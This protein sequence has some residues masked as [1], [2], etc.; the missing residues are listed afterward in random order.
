[1][2]QLT[3]FRVL[4]RLA[5][6][7]GIFLTFP[8][9]PPFSGRV[10]NTFLPPGFMQN[11]RA[12]P[13]AS[14]LQDGRVLVAGGF[15][16][17]GFDQH[18]YVSTEFFDPASGAFYPGPDM[19]APRLGHAAVTLEDNRI[20]LLGGWSA[21]GVTNT[22]EVYDPSNRRFSS[23][24]SM[25]IARGECTATLLQDGKVL[26]T[27]GVDQNERGLS[28]AEVFDPRTNS[29]SS[30]ASMMVPR[31][32]HTAT[33][34]PD[35]S[36]LIT[37]GGS[38][39]CPSKTV[40]RAAEVYDP[41]VG[42]FIPVGGLTSERYKH[43]AVLL[44]DGKVLVAGGSDARDWRGLLS[45]AELYDPSSRSF[46]SLPP[47]K[48]ARFKFPHAAVRLRSGDVL[49][50]SGAPFAEVF[51]PKERTFNS[52]SGGFEVAHYFG[53]ATLLADGRVLVVG[54]YT[55]AA[56]L[57]ATSGAWLYQP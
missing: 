29:F 49:I 13:T 54:G 36:V 37:G 27:G 34:L 20:L 50:A 48:A 23:V 53:S 4:S 8:Q 52:V 41:A 10:P 11:R 9:F 14:L 33:L 18:P 56:G 28:S 24:G 7:H 16:G 35:G 46:Q 12:S 25:A 2:S 1:M 3:V 5:L 26:V 21:S 6:L 38:C 17:S 40:Y 42:K 32:Q 22:A 39:D 44:A 43:T 47:M 45:S 51:R 57:P 31:A 30:A 55:Q 15:A 19:T